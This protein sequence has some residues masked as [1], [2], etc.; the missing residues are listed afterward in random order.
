[1][2]ALVVM[3]KKIARQKKLLLRYLK[4]WSATSSSLHPNSSEQ[5]TRGD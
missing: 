3:Q 5:E 1:M 2:K 4:I